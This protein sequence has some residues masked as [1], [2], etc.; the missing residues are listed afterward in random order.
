MENWYTATQQTD[1]R[2]EQYGKGGKQYNTPILTRK[3]KKY[4]VYI[5]I[6]KYIDTFNKVLYENVCCVM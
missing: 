5:H 2:Q 4:K 6:Y 3:D 1:T